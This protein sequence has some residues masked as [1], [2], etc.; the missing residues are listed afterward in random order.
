MGK[1]FN[2]YV[3]VHQDPAN[4][5]WFSPG[6]DVPEWAE[7][8][9][10]D[11]VIEGNEED[12]DDVRFRDPE[13]DP[14]DPATQFSTV[15]TLPPTA[16]AVGD[17]EENDVEDELDLDTLSKAELIE[18]AEERG[19]ETSGTKADLKERILADED[20]EADEE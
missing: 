1:K 6:D 17:V 5:V 12:V 10:G 15:N 4:S 9:V 8:L 2:A 13:N 11:H 16:P 20:D 18:L 19:L 3:A 14:D 7:G